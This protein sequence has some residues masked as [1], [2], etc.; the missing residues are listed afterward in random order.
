MDTINTTNTSVAH[1]RLLSLDILRILACF[2]VMFQHSSEFFYIGA[3]GKVADAGIAFNVGILSSLDRICVPL[4]VMLSGYL[5]LPMKVHTSAFL[6]KHIIRVAGPFL[7]WCIGYAVYYV[8]YRGDSITLMMEHIF[9]IPVNFGTDVG[10][11]WYIY[12]ILG[13]YLLIPIL[14]PW[15]ERCSKKELQGYLVIWLLTTFLPYFHLIFPQILGECYWNP[16][17]LLYYFTG[18]AGYL[19]LGYYFK[20]YG[21]F[22]TASSLA[23]TIIGYL[24]TASIFCLRADKVVNVADLELSWSFCSINVVMMTAGVF[25][26]IQSI[27]RKKR[28]NTHPFLA[29]LSN[30]TYGMFL[31]HIMILNFYHDLFTGMSLSLWVE[32][33]MLALCTFITIYIIISL[34]SFLPKSHYWIG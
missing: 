1:K 11:L 13:L 28:W 9:S 33:P 14:S 25:S 18:F 5:L 21:S 30:K 10:H 29:D 32:I 19:I 31:A 12:M 17:P 6:K 23:M 4:F 22:S 20:K 27:T 7:F 24:F 16:T 8:F 26:F 2:L 34:L 3:G 15:L